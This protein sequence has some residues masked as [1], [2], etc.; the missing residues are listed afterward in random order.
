MLVVIIFLIIILYFI[1]KITL[2]H[3]RNKK[4]QINNRITI[5]KITYKSTPDNNN[6]LS[7]EKFMLYNFEKYSI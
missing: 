7:E 1:L 6:P 5:P 3:L 2:N 4:T